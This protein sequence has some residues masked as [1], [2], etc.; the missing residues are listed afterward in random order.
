MMRMNRALCVRAGL[1]IAAACLLACGRPPVPRNLVLITLDTVRYDHLGI[2]GYGGYGRDTTP[3]LQRLASRSIVFDNAFAQQTN[4]N[5]SH[6][7]I[8]TGLYP[9]VHGNQGNAALLAP[10]RVT[11]A[12]IL[13]RQGFR[14]AGFVS[15]VTMEDRFSG[16]GRGFEVY[17]DKLGRKVRIS[18]RIAAR[19]A[20]A[21]LRGLRPA[22]RYFLFLHL[23]DAHGPYVAPRH[24]HELF[25]SADPGPELP[26]IP[27]YQQ[28]LHD[29]QPLTHQSDYVD[30]YDAMIRYEDDILWRLLP[31]INL[32]D[33]IVVVLADHGETLTERYHAL[34]HG[35]QL[36]DEQIHIPLVLS[37]PHARPRRIAPFVETV[38]LLPTLLELLGVPTPPG[39]R[40]QGRSFA[41][42]LDGGRQE[43]HT[44][45]FATARTEP[46]W[47]ADRGYEL[48]DK[49]PLKSVRSRRFKLIVYPGVA[50]DY[51]ELYDLA[52]DRGETRDVSA[53]YPKVR[54]S[55]REVL[56]RWYARRLAPG[57]GATLSAEARE[58]LQALGYV[59]N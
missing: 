40:P 54:D 25:A 47:F 6:A 7:S 32:E 38:D 46:S 10:D 9:H 56:E 23:Y 29:N 44:F 31:E 57:E 13:R 49:R 28:L 16:L 53:R 45:V 55:L 59:G 1:G 41:P 42:L 18:G 37:L 15:G 20:I 39:V 21:W 34:D 2:S 58:K 48:D 51:L 19:K 8:F 4:T 26:R 11:L 30:R 3:T 24:Y 50:R 17:E 12:Q 14:T 36:Y 33:T 43:L 22:E 52:A 27:H 35:A 5:P